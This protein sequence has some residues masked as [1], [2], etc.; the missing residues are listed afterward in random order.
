MSSGGRAFYAE[1]AI[2]GRK[3]MRPKLRAAIMA[4]LLITLPSGIVHTRSTASDDDHRRRFELV[5]VSN[6]GKQANNDNDRAAI[7][8][9]GRYV[10]FTSIADNLVP[11]DTN[12]SSDVF[13]R[14]R[15]TGTIERVSVGQSAVEC[16]ANSGWLDS[17]RNPDIS[18]DGPIVAI[19]ADTCYVVATATLYTAGNFV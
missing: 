4:A 9:D 17:L 5:S 10:T 12:L 16:D 2:E 11:G 3:A 19:A 13:V 7:S 6:E 8:A 18:R 14:D 15:E 1:P